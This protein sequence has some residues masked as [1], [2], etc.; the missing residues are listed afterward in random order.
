[1]FRVG[2]DLGARPLETDGIL[3]RRI[4]RRSKLRQGLLQRARILF[5]ALRTLCPFFKSV[6]Q[7]THV[8]TSLRV[9]FEQGSRIGSSSKPRYIK[10]IFQNPPSDFRQDTV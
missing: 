5:G 4:V 3:R 9:R 6:L 7:A 8:T 2:L 10:R 1:M